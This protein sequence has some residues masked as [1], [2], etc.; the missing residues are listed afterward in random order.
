MLT[1]LITAWVGGLGDASIVP[2]LGDFLIPFR[3]EL[4]TNRYKKNLAILTGPA[5][6]SLRLRYGKRVQPS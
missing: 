4:I 3:N 6:M 1:T 5:I 2:G